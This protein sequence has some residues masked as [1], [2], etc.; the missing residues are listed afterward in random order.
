MIVYVKWAVHTHGG[1]FFQYI[2]VSGNIHNC[3]DSLKFGSIGAV[4]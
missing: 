1:C 4:R 3:L 2:K